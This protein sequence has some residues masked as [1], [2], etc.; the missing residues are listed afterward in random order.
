MRWFRDSPESG[1]IRN[2]HMGELSD[3]HRRNLQ[4]IL[5]KGA[6]RC[7][8]I[9]QTLDAGFHPNNLDARVVA[10]PDTTQRVSDTVSY[11]HAHEIPIVTQG[12][13]TGLTG[14]GVTRLGELILQTTRMNRI[15]DIDENVGTAVVEAG[16]TLSQLQEACKGARLSVGVDLSARGSATL[17]GMVSTNAGGIQAFRHGIT[18]HRVLGVEAV[19]PDGRIL[20]ELKRVSKANE[21]YDIKQLLIGSEGTLGVI[22]KIALDLV[23][24]DNSSATAL[25][26]CKDVTDAMRLFRRL[27]FNSKGSL[28]CAEIMWPDYARITAAAL[29]KT[30]VL[31]FACDDDVFVLVE[32]SGVESISGESC[33]TRSLEESFGAREITGAIIA[34]NERERRDIWVIREESFVADTIY[35]H[36]LWYDISVPHSE[37]ASYVEG[38]FARV[39]DLDSELKVL[40]FGHLGDGNLHLTITSGKE[41]KELAGAVTEAVFQ[42]L[43]SMGGSFSAEHGIGT[44]KM[45]SLLIHG[46][47]TKVALMRE[48]KNLLDPKGLM[49]PG[50][51]IE[52]L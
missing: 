39:R 37:L 38:L 45:H 31:S 26:S 15:I 2:R 4:A 1:T 21:G 34:K 44:E 25:I 40:L 50:K 46:D 17:G 19:L 16:V 29:K 42:G 47:P 22:T 48:I 13:R 27:R 6:L 52:V 35:P 10:L 24:E 8:D 28:L 36:G 18:R 9:T 7:G 3:Q 20:N 41:L 30:D 11:C 51:V 49:N 12:G 33:L 14:A 23:E 5:G 43:S 32:V